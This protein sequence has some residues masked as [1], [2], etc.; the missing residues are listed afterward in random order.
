MS[1]QQVKDMTGQQVG[2][3]TVLGRGA[4]A[5]GWKAAWQCRCI[6][7]KEL[8]VSGD[9]LRG[10]QYSCGCTRYATRVHGM[11][12]TKAHNTWVRMRG[13]CLNPSNRAY[14]HYGGRGIKVCD[15]WLNSFENFLADMGEPKP[16]DSIER[17]DVNGDYTPEN[18]KWIPMAEQARNKRNVRLVDGKS[19]ADIARETGIKY[20]TLHARRNTGVE[21]LAAGDLRERVLTCRGLS[22]SLSEWS[23]RGGIKKTT[24]CQRIK[25]G[26]PVDRALRE[27]L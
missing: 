8:T 4:S 5:A 26:W 7:G 16:G 25:R 19:L 9:K 10:G 14:K 6:C 21:S 11:S 3:L 12:K 18:C 24:I 22:L 23:A 27:A 15:R 17:E 20:A 1:T 2:L 13:R